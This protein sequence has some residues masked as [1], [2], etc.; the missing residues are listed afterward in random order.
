VVDADADGRVVDDDVLEGDLVLR[1]VDA[2]ADLD[3]VAVGPGDKVV[4]G[5]VV[6]RAGGA[7][8]ALVDVGDV[9]PGLGAERVVEADADGVVDGDVR[10]TP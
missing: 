4:E 2:L 3:A 5:D 7:G 6:Q 10:W 8:D 9:G 1:L